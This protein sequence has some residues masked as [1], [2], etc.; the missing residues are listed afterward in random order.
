MTI[1]LLNGVFYSIPIMNTT[2][3]AS[4]L[5]RIEIENRKLNK[6]NYKQ[7]YSEISGYCLDTF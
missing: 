7:N 4:L 5:N 1:S 3:L 6:E 2:Y